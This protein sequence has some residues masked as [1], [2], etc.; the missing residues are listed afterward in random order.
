MKLNM[1]EKKIPGA[2]MAQGIFFLVNTNFAVIQRG[3][4]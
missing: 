3:V 4:R 2:Y 1:T